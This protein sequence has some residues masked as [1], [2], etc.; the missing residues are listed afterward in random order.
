M[1]G[2]ADGSSKSANADTIASHNRILCFSIGVNI[3]HVHGFGVLG[4]KLKNI[5]HLNAAGY[6]NR[7]LTAMGTD[8]AFL[9]FGKIMVLRPLYITLHIQSGIVI[10]V[11]ICTTGKI[12]PSFQGTVI[13]NSAIAV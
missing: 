12:V 8:T 7:R 2:L 6:C 13:Q 10:F 9:Y 11:N 5:A 4:S 3:G 1:M